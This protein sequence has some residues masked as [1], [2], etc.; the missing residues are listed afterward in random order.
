MSSLLETSLT[1]MK[2]AF[3]AAPDPIQGI[4]TLTSLIDLM[5]HICRCLQTQK[6]PASATMNMLFCA[7]SPGLYSF[8]TQEA[9]PADYFPF[10]NEVDAVPDFLACNS[11][12]ESKTLKATNACG[13]K[14]RADIVTMNAAVSDVFLANLPK[15][16]RETY[17]PIRMKQLNTVFLHMFDWFITKYGKTTTKDCK[18]NRQRMAADWDPSDGLESLATRLFIGTSY[19]STARYPMDDCDIIDISLRVIK[20]CGIYSEEYKNWIARKNETP[21]I[22]ETIDSFNEY[23]ADAIALVNQTAV[24]ALQHGYGMAAMDNDASIASYSELLANFGAAYTATQESMKTQAATMAAMQGQLTNIQQFCMAIGQQPPPNIYAPPQQQ[25]TFNNRR[26]RRNGGG[27][28]NGG[29]GG[30]NGGGSFPQQP[31]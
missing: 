5:L 15:A 2:G 1:S 28:G 3:P 21:P 4:P 6:T 9:Y 7:V 25:Y 13:R 26:A 14:T 30:G 24:P 20:R 11:D 12:N 22:I 19:A 23:W 31:A 10:P 17:E 16:I 27:H 18:E 8:F 29:T